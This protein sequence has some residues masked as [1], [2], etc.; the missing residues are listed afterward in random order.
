MCLKLCFYALEVVLLGR[1]LS[2]RWYAAN[3]AE[4]KRWEIGGDFVDTPLATSGIISYPLHYVIGAR[5]QSEGAQKAAPNSASVRRGAAIR[6]IPRLHFRLRKP[7]PNSYC[8]TSLSI[9]MPQLE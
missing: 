8:A 3:I 6:D 5:L 1:L 2:R 9:R 4:I 7:Q